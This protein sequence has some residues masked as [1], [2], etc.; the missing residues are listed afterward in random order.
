MAAS[1]VAVVDGGVDAGHPDLW[2]KVIN[3]STDSEGHG[4]HI[5]GII[6]GHAFDTQNIE[7]SIVFSPREPWAT[8]SQTAHVSDRSYAD[9]W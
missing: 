2:G 8:S 7:C 9:Y 5:A 6:A 3:S 1:I 4:T